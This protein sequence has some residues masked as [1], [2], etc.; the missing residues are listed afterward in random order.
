MK[1]IFF[2]NSAYFTLGGGTTFLRGLTKILIKNGYNVKVL[3]LHSLDFHLLVNEFKCAD[4]VCWYGECTLSDTFK[5][6]RLLRSL[7][8]KPVLRLIGETILIRRPSRPL[9]L[10]DNITKML[11]RV[12][13]LE[14]RS[15]LYYGV[16]NID[17]F[18]LMGKLG[19]PV[20]Y[21]PRGVDTE[22][23]KP[24]EKNDKFTVICNACPAS[25]VKGTDLLLKIIPEVVH[26]IP[27]VSLIILTGGLGRKSFRDM[28]KKY[29][30][31]LPRNVKCEDR[32]LSQKEMSS[33]LAKCHLLLFP[34]RFEAAGNLILEAQSSGVPVVSFNIP[35]FPRDLIINGLTGSL[36]KP[37]EI[38]EFIRATL[39]FYEIWL[40]E[41]QKYNN[42]QAKSRENAL[43]FDWNNVGKIF[44]RN[45]QKIIA[46]LQSIHA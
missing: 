11:K 9:H 38:D 15:S 26:L 40:N 3:S 17:D 41:P 12:V 31:R 7:K 24:S 30:E 29:E 19:F 1:N 21:T 32:W 4:I 5:L 27:E 25:F 37:Y 8:K 36:I 43:R 44:T 6:V 16:G 23:F 13:E 18:K 14:L 34:S 35:G 10:L 2:Y 28:L 45:L 46:D 39:N 33:L 22:I 42:I 20:F